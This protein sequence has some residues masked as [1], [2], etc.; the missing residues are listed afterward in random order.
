MSGDASSASKH[1]FFVHRILRTVE[2]VLVQ[3]DIGGEP[4]LLGVSGGGDSMAL[5]EVLGLLAPK[6]ELALHVACI[7]HGLRPEAADEAELV[8][9]AATVWGAG[10]HAVRVHP[11]GDDEDNLRRARHEALSG[12]ADRAGSRFIL[13]GHTA[14][15]QIETMLLRFLRGAGLGG[16]SGMRTIRPPFVRPL[17]S[18]HRGDLREL[19][20][21]RSVEWSEDPTNETDRYAR[22][23]LRTA[24][25]PVLERTFGTGALEHLLDL[26]PRWRADEEYL[27][28]EAE[29]VLAY[30]SRNGRSGVELDLTALT[31]A[32]PALQPRVLRRWI[33]GATGHTTASR[34][35]AAIERWM[36][37]RTAPLGRI[38]IAGATLVCE[39]GRLRL[40]KPVLPPSHRR[41]TF[42]R[43]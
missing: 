4:V 17:L 37:A 43:H 10:F 22:G 2:E 20:R 19:L 18:F 26:G 36:T 9:R 12:L 11:A 5:L 14:D 39:R 41:V 7:D 33:L 13:L 35:L 25:L 16:L 31:E 42:P 40:E 6:L 8:R 21:A 29:R 24:V 32:H 38:D 15:D 30:A 27:E 34:E 3:A 1:P 23:R 28:T